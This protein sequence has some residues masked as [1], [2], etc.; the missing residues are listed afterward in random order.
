MTLILSETFA[1]PRIAANGRFGASSSF[2]SIASSRS[3]SSPAYAGRNLAIP[4]VEACARWAV[5]NASLT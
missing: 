5:P 1:P 3:M 4:T 2:E